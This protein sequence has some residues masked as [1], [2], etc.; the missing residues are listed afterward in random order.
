MDAYADCKPAYVTAFIR[1]LPRYLEEIGPDISPTFR[2]AV[3]RI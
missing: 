2:P 3:T 1:N